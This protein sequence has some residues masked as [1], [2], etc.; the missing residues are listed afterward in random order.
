MN[1]CRVF[2][3]LKIIYAV[4]SQV[5]AYFGAYLGLF[6]YFLL[7]CSWNVHFSLV[8]HTN[9]CFPCTCMFRYCRIT[10]RAGQLIWLTSMTTLLFLKPSEA[11]ISPLL[12]F[13]F[14]CLHMCN[15]CVCVCVCA[16]VCARACG[17]VSD[18]PNTYVIA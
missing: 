17:G 12:L 14:H 9:V 4:W 1:V 15:V 10:L 16:C 11:R 2:W 7:V 6:K 3:N 13:K 18:G 5:S 8:C